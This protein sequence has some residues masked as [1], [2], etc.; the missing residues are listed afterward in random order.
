VI[1]SP[2]HE[3]IGVVYGVSSIEFELSLLVFEMDPTSKAPEYTADRP[4]CRHGLCFVNPLQG[5]P[6]ILGAGAM[7]PLGS[8]ETVSKPNADGLRGPPS[9]ERSGSLD[10][11]P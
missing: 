2:Y 11:H 3:G 8:E 1:G 4:D 10:S 6:E 7:S 9:I 5:F